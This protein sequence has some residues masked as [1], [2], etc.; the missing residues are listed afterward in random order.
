MGIKKRKKKKVIT[1]Q[2]Q[3]GNK[4]NAGLMDIIAGGGLFESN[5]SM[6]RSDM[7]SIYSSL[8]RDISTFMKD[9]SL[10]IYPY[11]KVILSWE[12]QDGLFIKTGYYLPSEKT[13]VIFCADRHPKDVLRSFAHEMIHHSQ[14]LN[15]V[16]FSNASSGGVMDNE[17]LKELEED[18]YLRGN[19]L[20]RGWTESIT[21]KGTL[22]EGL[23]LEHMDSDDVDLSSF[24]IKRNLNPKFWKDEKLSSEVRNHLLTIADDFIKYLDI[25]DNIKP[26]D[27]TLTGSISNFNWNKR[28]SDVDL[29]IILNFDEMDGDKDMVRN[30]FKAK[31]DLWNRLHNIKI[32][33][34]PVELYVQDVNEPHNSTGVYSIQKDEWNVEPQ[35]TN[36]DFNHLNIEYVKSKVAYYANWIDDLYRRYS[37]NKTNEYELREINKDAIDLFHEL[38]IL[39]RRDTDDATEIFEGNII[40]KSLRRMKYLDK[41]SKVIRDTYDSF[42][43]LENHT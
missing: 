15:G 9:N 39:R 16:D 8:M 29:H 40:F 26:V 27:I 32:Y 3:V 41:L 20:F 2:D 30:Y 10:L 12:K 38:K 21:N 17:M 22:N 25:P 13:I 14:N 36:M 11:P 43:S 19:I 34:F 28:Y 5:E 6:A 37:E 1:P 4:V 7:A 31:K 24:N 33:G 18:A 35:K 23:R 42:N